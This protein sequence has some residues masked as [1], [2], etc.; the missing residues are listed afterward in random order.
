MNSLKWKKNKIVE[1]S[2]NAI[3]IEEKINVLN[4]M[5]SVKTLEFYVS[6][7]LSQK[8]EFVHAKQKTK[9]SIKVNESRHEVASIMFEF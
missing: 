6:P 1:V 8:D 5:N 3:K 2:M 7:S 9:M 4:V